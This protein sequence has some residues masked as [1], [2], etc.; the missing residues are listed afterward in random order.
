MI[1]WKVWMTMT[2][3]G[4]VAISLWSF[5]FEDASNAGAR[6]AESLGA[7]SHWVEQINT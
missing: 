5:S 6:L 4:Q 1:E 7:S 2:T 3:G